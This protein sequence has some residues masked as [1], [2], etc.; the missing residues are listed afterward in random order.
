MFKNTLLTA[1]ILLGFGLSAQINT[2]SGAA[3][4]FGSNTSYEFGI[5]PTNLPTSGTYGKSSDVGT[6]YNAWKTA[7]VENCGTDKA[8]VKFDDPSMTVSEGIAYG[9]LLAAYAADKDLFDRL[10]AYYK[11]F[12]NS[13]GV[14]HWKISGCNSVNQQNGAT[15]AE[16][17]AAMALIVASKQWTTSTTPHNYKT[18]GVALINAI[19]NKETNADGTFENGD[20]WKPACR[21]PSYQ[22][23]AYARAFKKFMAE[24]GSNQ[25]AFW[26]NV[27]TK[28]EALLSANA[29]A[30][31]GLNTNWCTPAGPP[32]SSCSGSGTA[33]DK[34]GY[35]ACRAPWRQGVDV[36]WWGTTATGNVPTVVNRAV[37]FWTTKGA[38]NVQGSN[39]MNHDGTGSGD[40]NPAF[41]GPV[42]AQTLGASNTTAHQTFCNAMYTQNN[43][44]NIQSNQ[45]FTTIL[46]MIGLFV[47]SGNFWNPYATGGGTTPTNQNPT[48]SLTAPA[49][50][51]AVCQGTAITLTATAADAD[52]NISKVEFYNGTT[53]LGTV[54]S[55]PYTYSYSPTASGTLSITAKAFDNA[56][57]AGTATSTAVSVTV[58]ASPAAPT[59]S[60]VGFC[61][62]TTATAL[63]ATGTSLKWYGTNATGGTA[64]TTA[65]TPTTT[66]TGTTTYY[67]TQT[68]NNCESARTGITVT[69]NQTA[70]PTV[71]TQVTY[72]QG[73][74]ATQL[75]ATGTA[76]KWYADASTQTTLSAAPTPS[77]TANGTTTYY[78]SQTLNSCESNRASITVTVSTHPAAPTV[79]TPVEYCEGSTATALTA[80]GQSLKWYTSSTATSSQASITP[81]TTTIGSTTYYVSQSAGTCES[82]RASLVVT[83]KDAPNAPTVSNLSYQLN[84]TATQLAA[85]GTALKWYTSATA[86]SSSATA[87][88]PTT[89]SSGTTSY[90]VTQSANG[91]ESPKAEIKV[92][93]VDAIIVNKT[94]VAITVDGTI[95][96][97]WSKASAN[98]FTKTVQGTISNTADLS[99][100]FKA[101]WDD[102]YF[103]VL[104]EITDE[105]KQNNSTDRYQDDAVEVFFDF[106]NDKATTYGTNDVQYTFRYNDTGIGVSS[107][108]STTGVTFTITSTTAGYVLEARIPWTTLGGTAKV[109]DLNGFDFQIN[110]DD[111]GGDRDGKMS[112]KAATDDAWQNPSL[113]GTTVLGEAVSLCTQPAKPSLSVSKLQACEGE[114]IAIS[115]SNTNSNGQLIQW[116]KDG[117]AIANQTQS[118]LTVSATGSYTVRYA[119]TYLTNTSCFTNSDAVSITI[120]AKPSSPTIIGATKA[121]IYSPTEV[122]NYSVTNVNGMTYQWTLQNATILAGNGTNNLTIEFA[123]SLGG[124]SANLSVVATNTNGCQSTPSALNIL[125]D[126]PNAVFG[127]QE[128]QV[129]VFPNPFDNSLSIDG[130]ENYEMYDLSGKL[131]QSGEITNASI[132]TQHLSNA[133][134]ILKVINQTGSQVVKVTKE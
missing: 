38:A 24:N 70:T 132:N 66:A 102:T 18:D 104:G 41:W 44:V 47:Q 61:Q 88:T 32:S 91:C 77:T 27:A 3:K 126:C 105:V 12:R 81:S 84:Q 35:D 37:D 36:I 112:W 129:N 110:D 96:A 29:H 89:A 20:M 133:V 49:N 30:T 118:G 83:V 119:D 109:G 108:K 67:V 113:F 53:L 63:T 131:V 48:V 114:T 45:Y 79:T 19:K 22:A 16:L 25:D 95:D 59:T 80:I 115:S 11:N 64:S 17:D 90:F 15:D 76:L 31:S 56:A 93:V 51:A 14:M 58:N 68:T 62:N 69:V 101:M 107:G 34:F 100:N 127:E 2:P 26:D 43:S 6:K 7:Y 116:Y 86:T 33:P 94:P 125:F 75:S 92:S 65:P 40:R 60:A 39:N 98:A 74:T 134:Y 52:G 117:T 122:Y 50:N 21:N 120:N 57:T 121:C 106:G 78:V 82:P 54:T 71:T 23:P 103:Y 124:T 9:M 46:Q 1:L 28:T 130:F 55:S 85:T 5:M 4:P 97:I 99:G 123:K 42:G 13:N 128:V 73:Q 8:R 87:P 10:W 72:C 111:N